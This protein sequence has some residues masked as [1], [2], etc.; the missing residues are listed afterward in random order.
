MDII[1]PTTNKGDTTMIDL[2]AES[3]INI[4]HTIEHYENDLYYMEKGLIDAT[5]IDLYKKELADLKQEL[6]RRY[7]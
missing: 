6:K 4:I 2:S 1:D 3:D 5:E 7:N